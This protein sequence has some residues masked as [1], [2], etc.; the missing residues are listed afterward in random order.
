MIN[1]YLVWSLCAHGTNCGPCFDKLS[2]TS[3][4]RTRSVG[5][6]AVDKELLQRA[7]DPG[8]DL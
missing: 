8:F 7:I 4:V 3:G 6:F 1:C 2:M 5:T